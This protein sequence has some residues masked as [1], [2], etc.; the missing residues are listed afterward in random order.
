MKP[1][2]DLSILIYEKALA[3]VRSAGVEPDQEVK[4]KVYALS[5]SHFKH[6]AMLVE[7][8]SR[9]SENDLLVS[10]ASIIDAMTM[11]DLAREK[12]GKAIK[13]FRK[14][15]R[16]AVFNKIDIAKARLEEVLRVL[17]KAISLNIADEIERA[18]SDIASYVLSTVRA[19]AGASEPVKP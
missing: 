1:M 8:K 15:F 3:K 2:V 5:V 18:S 11:L 12:V 9:M 7:I 17:D 19:R 14:H 4:E 10:K 6:L 13:P 16:D